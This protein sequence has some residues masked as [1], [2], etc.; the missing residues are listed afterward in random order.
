M[1]NG[2]VLPVQIRKTEDGKYALVEVDQFD[3][4]HRIVGE[5]NTLEEAEEAKRERDHRMY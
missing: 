4:D 5:F 2:V 1:V 3:E